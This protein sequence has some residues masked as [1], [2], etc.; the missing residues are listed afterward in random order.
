M[1]NGLMRA[2]RSPQPV[3]AFTLVELLVVIA[4]IGILVALLLPAVQAAREAARRTSCK[5]QLRQHGIALQN[6]HDVTGSLPPGVFR[7]D[8]GTSA[9]NDDVIHPFVIYTLPY[10]EEGTKFSIYDLNTSWNK[11][12]IEVLSQLRSPLPTWQCPSDQ[13]HCMIATTGDATLS[14]QFDDCKGSYGI[15]W[16]TFQFNDQWDDAT[17]TQSLA[18]FSERKDRRRGV[19]DINFGAK[20]SQVPDGTS[21]TLAMMEMRQ[22]PSEDVSAVDRRARIWNGEVSGT[23]QLMTRFTPNSQDPDSDKSSTCVNLE[24][25]GLPCQSVGAGSAYLTSRSNHP[26]GVNVVLCDSSV[27]FVNDN[28]EPLVWIAASTRNGEEVTEAFP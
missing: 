1:N 11:Q 2:S 23:Y 8:M 14:D 18:A 10:M 21:K 12:E 5:N 7:D 19:F 15:N 9:G 27:Q 3:R 17:I 13:Q 24:A 22:T 4:I 28:I 20:F 25:Q 6:Y 16:G 26:G